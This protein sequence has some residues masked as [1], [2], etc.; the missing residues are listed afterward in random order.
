[1]TISQ[2]PSKSIFSSSHALITPIKRHNIQIKPRIRRCHSPNVL[3]PT[4]LP[5]KPHLRRIEPT[6]NSRQ[7]RRRLD[8][9][10]TV[11]TLTAVFQTLTYVL[12]ERRYPP[13]RR[14][15]TL[16]Q[17]LELVCGILPR[18]CAYISY[19]AVQQNQRA[20]C[21]G[22]RTMFGIWRLHASMLGEVVPSTFWGENW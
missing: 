8:T 10:C 15:T 16:I 1:M 20:G 22:L 14:L 3:A 18:C 2:F 19:R 13:R 11:L 6:H 12:R 21:V 5:L 9:K 4:Q 17:H 7:K